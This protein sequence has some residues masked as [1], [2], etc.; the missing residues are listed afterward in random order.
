MSEFKWSYFEIEY[1]DGPGYLCDIYSPII[2]RHILQVSIK[3]S[4]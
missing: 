4:C 3:V 1:F 2:G